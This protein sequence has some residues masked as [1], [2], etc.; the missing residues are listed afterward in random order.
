[1]GSSLRKVYR[2]RSLRAPNRERHERPN[3]SFRIDCHEYCR[4]RF[5]MH[6]A[7]RHDASPAAAS[8]AAGQ[9]YGLDGQVRRHRRRSL[10]SRH[11]G[12][13]DQLRHGSRILQDP[14]SAGARNGD[15]NCRHAR[16]GVRIQYGRLRSGFGHGGARPARG[17]RKSRRVVRKRATREILA[18]KT[19]SWRLELSRHELRRRAGG[20]QFDGSNHVQLVSACDERERQYVGERIGQRAVVLDRPFGEL[21]RLAGVERITIDVRPPSA[22]RQMALSEFG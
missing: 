16:M 17:R 2:P 18:K 14:Q 19:G 10:A 22:H 13:A 8:A 1:M 4:R 11:A 9:A 20:L 6:D 7:G 21:R 15:C 3:R 5:W 12:H